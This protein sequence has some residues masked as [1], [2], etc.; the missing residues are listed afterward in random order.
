[1]L[2]MVKCVPIPTPTR[3]VLLLLS[4]SPLGRALVTDDRQT[5][6]FYLSTG[7]RS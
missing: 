3:V 7:Q 4:P 2:L 6:F 1:M 5:F